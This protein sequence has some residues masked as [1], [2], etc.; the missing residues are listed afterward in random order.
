MTFTNGSKS[1]SWNCSCTN[2]ANNVTTKNLTFASNQCSGSGYSYNCCVP[3]NG[4]NGPPVNMTCSNLTSGLNCS[5]IN[6]TYN[7]NKSWSWNCTCTNK[8][9]VAKNL[10]ISSANCA[11]KNPQEFV[12]C[13]A[14]SQMV[15]ATNATGNGTK[16][17][18]NTG[19]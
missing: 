1:W 13:V 16:P 10:N 2:K 19:N 9:L 11:P 15:N 5:C 7:S 3:A 12:C 17:G 4:T 14:S 6:Q 18:N 8:T